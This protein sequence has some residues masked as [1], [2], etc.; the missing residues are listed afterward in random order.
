MITEENH[1][2]YAQDYLDGQLDEAT[3]AAFEA[4]AAAREA[5]EGLENAPRVAPGTETFAGKERLHHP[6][7][8]RL[9]YFA[10]AAAEGV[11]AEEERAVAEAAVGRE[12]F[13]R[14][15]AEYARMRVVADRAIRFPGKGRLRRPAWGWRT[16]A[17]GVA[18]ALLLGVGIGWLLDGEVATAHVVAIAPPERITVLSERAVPPT[19]QIMM[20]KR[21]AVPPPVVAPRPA[22]PRVRL[23]EIEVEP[24]AAMLTV[25]STPD[26]FPGQ[27][28]VRA[29]PVPRSIRPARVPLQIVLPR[30]LLDRRSLLMPVA[31]LVDA[32]REIAAEVKQRAIGAWSLLKN[33]E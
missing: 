30:E 3:R 13:A 10:I 2:L 11:L 26:A 5:V 25:A 31:M 32:G 23:P 24:A 14:G 9:D 16:A 22:V 1:E 29:L 18:A 7:E 33:D 27:L 28:P 19:G 17:S 4:C 15:V 12:A 8:S 20:A 21:V 6:D